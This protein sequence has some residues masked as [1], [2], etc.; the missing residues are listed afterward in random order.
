MSTEA[1]IYNTKPHPKLSPSYQLVKT[2]EVIESFKDFGYEVTQL[3]GRVRASARSAG[4]FSRHMV[5]LRSNDAK[6]IVGGVFPEIVVSNSHDGSSAF[7]V[8]AGLFRLVCSNGLVVGQRGASMTTRIK[9]QGSD[10]QTMVQDII[11]NIVEF[12]PDL[13][14]RV[15]RM[16]ETVLTQAAQEDFSRNVLHM[17]YG[18]SSPLLPITPLMR[19]RTE[20]AGN[21]LWTTFNVIQENMVVGGLNGVNANGNRIMTGGIR[22]A[23]RTF[24]FNSE[25]WDLAETYIETRRGGRRATDIIE[26]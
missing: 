8:S 18:D 17:I 25:L 3:I 12:L 14:N 9:H 26:A 2:A 6:P 21:D 16:R 15:N 24:D 7:R 23:G 13:E 5:R 11:K 1:A 19:R 10:V 22:A 20:D 4:E